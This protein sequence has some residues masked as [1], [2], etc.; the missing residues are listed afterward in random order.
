[1]LKYP[2]VQIAYF[3]SDAKAAA[4]RAVREFGAGPFFVLERIQLGWGEHRG[5]PQ[6]FLHTSA[7]GQWGGLMLEL[8][9]QDE[10]GPSP[11][12]DMYQAGEEGIHHMAMMVDSLEQAYKDVGVRGY[13]LAARAAVPSGL[14]FA[15]VD[16]V[17]S[18]GHMLEIYEKSDQ[19]LGFYEMV[20]SASDGWDGSDPVRV[21]G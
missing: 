2:I 3:V 5:R 17:A 16:T 18:L 1:M 14:E 12:R 11:F 4:L 8:V 6:D 21:L 9:Q 10:E 20:R 19:L 15:F 7:Y 13:E